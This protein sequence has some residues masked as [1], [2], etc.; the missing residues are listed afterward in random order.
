[1]LATVLNHPGILDRVAERLGTMPFTDSELDSL[2]AEILITHGAVVG[3]GRDLDRDGLLDHLRSSGFGA[4][5]DRVLGPQVC[6]HASFAR[7]KASPDVALAGWEHVHVLHGRAA[8]DQDLRVAEERL[9]S[10][11]T[12][13]ALARLSLIRAGREHVFDSLVMD[14]AVPTASAALV[15]GH[16]ADGDGEWDTGPD[17]P[18]P[19]PGDETGDERNGSAGG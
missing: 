13:D 7:A 1:M 10:D 3:A 12:E 2:R 19:D 8:L 4:V 15:G 14:A 5:V 11:M 18:G 16:G 9:A 6:M 17:D